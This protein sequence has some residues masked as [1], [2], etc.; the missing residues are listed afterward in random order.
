MSY[1]WKNYTGSTYGGYEPFTSTTIIK[2]P[3]VFDL[4]PDD[5]T[6]LCGI[7]K[8]EKGGPNVDIHAYEDVRAN[9]YGYTI[10]CS[11]KKDLSQENILKNLSTIKARL[12]MAFA[13]A[14]VPIERIECKMTPA[15]KHN[16]IT[17]YKRLEMYGKKRPFVAC[18][19]E[20]GRR[21]PDDTRIDTLKGMTI[22]IVDPMDY[23]DNYLEFKGIADNYIHTGKIGK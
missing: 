14:C 8:K 18:F 22:K 2:S 21:L 9:N 17:A 13:Q 6:T 1:T 11:D 7:P 10:T 16:I 12:M 15:I 23:G 20:Y 3:E 4:D 19:D 5:F